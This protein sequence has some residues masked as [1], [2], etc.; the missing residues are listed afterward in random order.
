MN[1]FNIGP[2]E[3]LLILVVVLVVFGPT[4]IPDIGA[5]IG[6]S[7]R[8]F[9]EASK[10]LT[11]NLDLEALNPSTIVDVLAAMGDEQPAAAPP[12]PIEEPSTLPAPVPAAALAEAQASAAA[13]ESAT[14]LLPAE[15]GEP[16][17]VPM[18]APDVV[19]TDVQP[20]TMP[21]TTPD[22]APADAQAPETST[23][24]PA[25]FVIAPVREPSEVSGLPEAQPAGTLG[26]TALQEPAAAPAPDQ[27]A[28]SRVE[29]AA[30]VTVV[31][32]TQVSQPQADQPSPGASADG[33]APG[34]ADGGAPPAES[35]SEDSC[36]DGAPPNVSIA[37]EPSRVLTDTPVEE[38]D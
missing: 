11:E 14:L 16:S 25:R 38:K 29:Q 3:L 37:G 2:M 6:K 4:K 35:A 8:Q 22:I 32:E 10:E 5:S 12:A 15:A 26:S 34:A 27:V 18:A 24:P 20:T 17:A 7:L 1:F 19:P 36:A 9:R 13:P 28:E 23:K 21:A 33:P 31:Q 30:T